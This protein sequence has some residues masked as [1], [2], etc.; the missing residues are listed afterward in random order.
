MIGL[1][2]NSIFPQRKEMYDLIKPHSK[3]ICFSSSNIKWQINNPHEMMIEGRYFNE[4][5]A[6]FR[7]FGIDRGD[8]YIVTPYDTR[9]FVHWKLEHSD[10]VVLLGG[11]MEDLTFTLKFY[12]V[13][14]KLEGRDV[15]GIS[16]G[17]LVLCDKYYILPHID[18]YYDWLDIE[19]GLGLVENYRLL[20]HFRDTK[21]HWAN[22]LKV[23]GECLEGKG[24]PV[25]LGDDEGI[26]IDGKSIKY[27]GGSYEKCMGDI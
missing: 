19:E 3:V 5:Y 18:D 6:P 22:Y 25:A 26:L 10:L 24:I 27:V 16:A 9:E 8:F 1:F 21:E 14:D 7:E 17:A 11:Q 4:Q 15:I 13:W 12:D 20:V 2:S 23:L